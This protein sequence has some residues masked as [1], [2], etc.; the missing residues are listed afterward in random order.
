VTLSKDSIK[1][2]PASVGYF[3]WLNAGLILLV[4]AMA[5]C[6]HPPK[7]PT[8]PVE[9]VPI[10]EPKN[11][12]PV[13]ADR[14][15]IRSFPNGRILGEVR[16]GDQVSI[17]T[18]RGNWMYCNIGDTLDAYIWAPSL[19]FPKLSYL[20][21]RTY[22][23]DSDYR[24]MILDT[25]IQRLGPPSEISQE[26]PHYQRVMYNNTPQEAQYLFGT[27][28]FL[29]LEFSVTQGLIAEVIIDL[30]VK[31]IRQSELLKQMGIANEHPTYTGFEEVRWDDVFKGLG[32]VTL[33]RAAG[34]F[35]SFSK[36]RVYKVNPERWG[37]ALTLTSQSCQIGK[38]NEVTIHMIVENIDSVAYSDMT[39]HLSFYAGSKSLIYEAPFGPLPDIIVPHGYGEIFVDR[40]IPELS[41]RTDSNYV[42]KLV[43]ARPLM[44]SSM[45]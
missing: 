44:V 2:Y 38:N 3:C 32:R 36:I 29:H 5:G 1:K 17:V 40:I 6:V 11:T 37:S 28:G 18:P 25:L 19:G 33:E 15:N 7:A 10:V 13:T 21:I 31:E 23:A 26:S 42:I 9:T 24:P 16:K 41:G 4:L 22:F 39:Y 34:S 8:P 27:N 45:P 20:D 14:E 35:A 30:G 43:S 12:V